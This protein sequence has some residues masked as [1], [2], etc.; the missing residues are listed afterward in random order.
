MTFSGVSFYHPETGRIG[1]SLQSDDPDQIAANLDRGLAVYPA[2]L[3]PDR[4]YIDVATGSAVAIPD[5][6]SP[7]H[8]W[9]HAQK[10]WIVGRDRVGDL[11]RARLAATISKSDLLLA[12][13][14]AGVLTMAEA[15]AAVDGAAPARVGPVAPQARLV[16]RATDRFNRLD[17]V[18][19]IAAHFLGLGDDQLDRIFNVRGDD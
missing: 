4:Y 1:L 7:D 15:D 12:L 6:P 3:P 19:Q 11:H 10:S 5:Q 14:D 16:W 2:A 8:I 9:D 17:P 13:V 18:I